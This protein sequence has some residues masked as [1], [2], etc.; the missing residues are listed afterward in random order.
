MNSGVENHPISDVPCFWVHPCQTA[1]AIGTVARTWHR[2]PT[3]DEYLM[4]WI[5]LVAASV[6]LSLPRPLAAAYMG[7]SSH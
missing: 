5:G 2:E 3:A 6:G 4:F 7:A 1:E